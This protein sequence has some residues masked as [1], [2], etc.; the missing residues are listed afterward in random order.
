MGSRW[1][2]EG[3]ALALQWGRSPSACTPTSARAAM[4]SLNLETQRAPASSRTKIDWFRETPVGPCH[5]G[6]WSLDAQAA[7]TRSYRTLAGNKRPSP[8][9]VRL[10]TQRPSPTLVAAISHTNLHERCHEV[11]CAQHAGD[12]QRVSIPH[13]SRRDALV[14]QR[15]QRL[16]HRQRRVQQHHLAALG[17]EL[18]R[19]V[20][21][22][23]L[24]YAH[25]C[26]LLHGQKKRCRG[27]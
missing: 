9:Q 23:E 4:D 21:S 14:V 13:R 7:A 2:R 1:G 11:A 8:E 27:S 3:V 26:V 17:D 24:T 6:R 22:K 18:V 5:S 10:T 25:A 19:S 20:A 16:A 12:A 15:M